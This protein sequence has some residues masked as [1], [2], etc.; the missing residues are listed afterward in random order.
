MSMS[1]YPLYEFDRSDPNLDGVER[2]LYD[3]I[4]AEEPWDLVE[5]FSRLERV[6]GSEDEKRA[7]EYLVERLDALG[8]SHE[9][10]DPE[11]WISIPNDASLRTVAPEGESFESA[12]T[13]SFSADETITGEVVHVEGDGPQDVDEVLQGALDSVDVD[14]EGKIVAMEGLL[15]IEAVSQ[16]ED[17]GAI[18][19]VGVHPHETEPHEGIATPVWGGIPAPGEEDRVPDVPIVN[20]SKR[21]GE[22]LLGLLEDGSVEV[23]LTADVTTDW[24]ECPV[25]VADVPGKADPEDDDFVLLHGHYDSWHF[26]VTDNATGDAGLLECARVFNEFSEDL[27]RDLRVAWWPAHSTGRYGGSTWFADEFANELAENCVA[28]VDMD[29]PGTEDATEFEYMVEWMPEAND[30][31]KGAIA[32][33]C[34]KE[35]TETRP[36]RAGD[37]SFNNLGVTGVYM[38]SSNIP[39]AVQEERGYHPVGGCGGNSNAWH[40]T[41]DTLDTADPDVLVRDIRV[42]AITVARLLR[43]TVV[44]LDHE[45]NVRRHREIIDEYDAAA[46]DHFDLEP[47]DEELAALEERVAA[48]YNAVDQGDVDPATANDVVLR[49]SRRLTRLNFCTEGQFEHDP[50]TD[51][52]PYPG[53]EPAADLPERS[54]DAYGFLKTDLRRKRSAAINELR[55]ARATVEQ[56]LD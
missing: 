32:D 7:A 36:A 42:Y 10:Y 43:E 38:L 31:A 44:P 39:R 9:R 22:R 26:G 37:Y 28:Q 27:S 19:F 2:G 11:L 41:T 14:V 25:V 40:L 55:R 1:D 3:E 5:E 17:E 56:A 46:G 24:F 12:K 33:V 51:R 13:V 52:P 50:A 49:L 6:S 20:L 47:V 30:L 4:S 15:P 54:G 21:D 8:V 23:E 16:L 18:G 35:A 34:G 45:R 48:F 29:S 53:L